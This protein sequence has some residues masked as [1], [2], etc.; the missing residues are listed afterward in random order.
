MTVDAAVGWVPD[1]M[2]RSKLVG[3]RFV[4]SPDLLAEA[5]EPVVVLDLARPGA[6]DHVPA[7]LV[8]GKRVLGFASHVDRDG[9]AAARA[10]GCE[11]LPRSEL[12]RRWPDLPP[13]ALPPPALPLP[14]PPGVGPDA[15]PQ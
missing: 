2:D 9:I 6:T 15:G 8:A 13:P 1:L 12:F 4:R 3:V 10:L 5:P 7:L 14:T 11:V